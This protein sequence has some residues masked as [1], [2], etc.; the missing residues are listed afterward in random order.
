M[1]EDTAELIR[2]RFQAQRGRLPAQ[3]RQNADTGHTSD[4][5]WVGQYPAFKTE[6]RPFTMAFPYAGPDF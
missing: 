6:G 5:R 4:R 3:L 1:D 2:L